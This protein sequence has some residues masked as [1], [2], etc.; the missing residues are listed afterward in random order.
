MAFSLLAIRPHEC[1]TMPARPVKGTLRRFAPL[2]V[3]V[4]DMAN[5]HATDGS[6]GKR[7]K[8]APPPQALHLEYGSGRVYIF[9][10]E[11]EPSA[12]FWYIPVFTQCRVFPRARWGSFYLLKAESQREK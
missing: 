11:Y 7:L 3:P 6:N 8:A 10:Q 2:T 4:C 5:G 12:I 1:P 9:G